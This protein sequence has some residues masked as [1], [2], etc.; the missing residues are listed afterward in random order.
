MAEVALE[1]KGTHG[2]WE[3]VGFSLTADDAQEENRTGSLSLNDD[4]GFRHVFLFGFYQDQQ[5]VWESVAGVDAEFDARR[6]VSSL[7]LEKVSDLTQPYNFPWLWR[8]TVPCRV[9]ARDA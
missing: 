2:Q 4:R 7:E 6:V 1:M 5:G 3:K 9:V 8:G